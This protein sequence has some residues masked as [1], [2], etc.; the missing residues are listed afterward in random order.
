M[1]LSPLFDTALTYATH[2]HAHQ[3]R[4]ST[5]IPYI[6]HLLG[7][8]SIA[9]EY[10]ATEEEAIGA[11]L[12]DAGED[13]GGEGRIADI[14][15]R[16]GNAVADIV[17]GCSDTLEEHKPD[18][19]TRKEAYIAHLSHTTPSI[20]FVS[21]ADKLHNARAIL[22]DHYRIGD[23]VFERFT[24]SKAET[25]WYYRA[26]TTAFQQAQPSGGA[27]ELVEELDRTVSILEQRG[28]VANG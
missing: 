11:L 27:R 10:G 24:A 21:C 19:R 14:R 15:L 13:A 16:F 3:Q 26:L 8:L 9:L 28:Q 17:A 7:V 2:I 25:L 6:T 23:Q 5:E 12:H 22:R 20:R 1:Y 18:W 4:K